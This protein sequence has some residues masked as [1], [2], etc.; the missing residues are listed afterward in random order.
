MPFYSEK[1]REDWIDA[2]GI[3]MI[4]AWG[5]AHTRFERAVE[6]KDVVSGEVPTSIF[7]GMIGSVTIL[8]LDQNAQLRAGAEPIELSPAL[9]ALRDAP[10]SP[11]PVSSRRAKRIKGIEDDLVTL[12]L[13][14]QSLAKYREE[15]LKIKVDHDLVVTVMDRQAAQTA[16]DVQTRIDQLTSELDAIRVMST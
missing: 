9:V 3:G 14:L 1:E 11:P 4:R 6:H 5:A 8:P 15:A 7:T 12:R 16:R 2:H 13:F 10:P